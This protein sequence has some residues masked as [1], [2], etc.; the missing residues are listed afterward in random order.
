MVGA[1]TAGI[2]HVAVEERDVVIRSIQRE[3][4]S[5]DGGIARIEE[6]IQH[7]AHDR[8]EGM[9]RLG[10]L[11]G[12]LEAHLGTVGEPRDEG[13]LRIEAMQSLKMHSKR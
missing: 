5:L 8:R 13:S 12:Q 1:P 7:H 10:L 2:V 9:E 3:N 4:G 6:R 11:A